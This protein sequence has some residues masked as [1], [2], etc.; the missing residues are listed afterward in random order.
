LITVWVVS[1]D[2]ESVFS[3]S[4]EFQGQSP[5]YFCI[6]WAFTRIISYSEF[7]LRL[8]SI[9]GAAGSLWALYHIGKILLNKELALLSMLFLL[10]HPLFLDYSTNARPYSI[11]LFFYLLSTLAL[12][13]YL[14]TGN[15]KD[16]IFWAASSIVTFYCHYL[17]AVGLLVHPALVSLFGFE[18][19]RLR[20]LMCVCAVS[21]ILCIPGLMHL[22][23]IASKTQLY[24]LSGH[25][26]LFALLF[27]HSFGI[28]LVS[29]LCLLLGI[30]LTNRGLVLGPRRPQSLAFILFWAFFGV[31]FVFLIFHIFDIQ[32]LLQRYRYWSIGAEALLLA[33]VAG[34]FV[35]PRYKVVLVMIMMCACAP[36]TYHAWSVEN[37]RDAVGFAS[38]NYGDAQ[39]LF[40]Y[41]GLIETQAPEWLTNPESV[42]YLKA[43][44]TYYPDFRPEQFTLLPHN[45]QHPGLK[46][47]LEAEVYSK[48]EDA[49]SFVVITRKIFIGD[50]LSINFVEDLFP[51]FQVEAVEFGNIT[52]MHFTRCS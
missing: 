20:D 10:I 23:L 16:L 36:R 26:N 2:L 11:G 3:R 51:D 22:N 37:W 45:A 46:T 25:T 4:I 48:T 13:R 12:C 7:A 33:G 19:I 27:F 39:P 30:S 47:Y 28:T 38:K 40:L 14:R 41:S 32:L 1:D 49:D 42:N 8:P 52:V 35:A 24:Q 43:P 44:V 6:L 50:I 29:A 21:V 5:F 18:R 31:F 15:L 17:F 34:M 9:L